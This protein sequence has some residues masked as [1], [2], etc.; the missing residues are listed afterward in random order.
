MRITNENKAPQYNNNTSNY[1]ELLI[2]LFQCKDEGVLWADGGLHGKSKEIFFKNHTP[3]QD[4]CQL[5]VVNMD[6]DV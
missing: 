1:E 3:T 5:Q 4:L 6:T 2:D